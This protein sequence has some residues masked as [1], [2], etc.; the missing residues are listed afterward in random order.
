MSMPLARFA[1]ARWPTRVIHQ[2]WGRRLGPVTHKA[3]VVHD[4]R[5]VT[6]CLISSSA[7]PS[8]AG[9]IKDLDAK[10]THSVRIRRFALAGERSGHL[11]AFA[12]HLLMVPTD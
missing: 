10:V 3:D 1:M 2:N 4:L 8:A 9:W 6:K 7:S 5:S 11:A 12:G